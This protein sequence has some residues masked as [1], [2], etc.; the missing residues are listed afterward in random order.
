[1]MDDQHR[2]NHQNHQNQHQQPAQAYP[3]QYDNENQQNT[4]PM[5]ASDVSATTC[6]SASVSA[7]MPS[8]ASSSSQVSFYTPSMPSQPPTTVVSCIYWHERGDYYITSVDCIHLL[9]NLLDT[10][11]NVEEK[12]RVRRNLEG[13]RPITVSKSRA[14]T[15]EFFKLIMGFPNPKPRNIEKDVKVFDWRS[16]PYLLKKIIT[17]YTAIP[18]SNTD[19]ASSSTGSSTFSE[20]H[21]TY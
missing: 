1:M 10:R 20:H 11:F 18:S 14:N 7:P 12:N 4:L 21:A 13:F 5:D 17:K 8:M 6:A 3:Q 16:L 15:A 9:E 19:H 2:E